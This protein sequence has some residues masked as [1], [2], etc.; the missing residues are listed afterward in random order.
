MEL[1]NI[2]IDAKR[3][4]YNKEGLGSYARTLVRDLILFQPEH[5]YYLY[6]PYVPD[7]DLIEFWENLGNVKIKAYKGIMPGSL[8]RSRYIVKDL[9]KDKIDT[10]LGLSNELPYG[11]HKTSIKAV[12]TIHD[13][14]YKNFPQ[15]FKLADR[16]IYD[17]KFKYAVYNSD[18]VLATSNHTKEDI[19]SHFKV[20]SDK[21]KVLYQSIDATYR[22]TDP[23]KSQ[24]GKHFL[25]VG[26]INERKNLKILIS[27]YEFLPEEHRHPVIV[28]GQGKQYLEEVRS[29]LIEKGLTSHFIFLTHVSNIELAQ[30]YLDAICLVF[31]SQYEGFGIPIL[32]ALSLNVP[33]IT[34]NCTSLPEVVGSFGI[35]IEFNSIESLVKA[36]IK[37][38]NKRYREQLLINV[39]SHL[40]RFRPDNIVDALAKLFI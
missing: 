23:R 15:Q 1:M 40:S 13:L 16:L 9:K 34:N 7:A 25:V 17:K 8:W 36:L 24:D 32:E 5:V 35:I 14:I 10:Y 2:G 18:V 21:I 37:M 29:M 28:V 30:L 6:T 3:L 27:A 22:T 26:T 20:S 33:V 19:L 31:P 39:D 11:I 38:D 4:F 12:V